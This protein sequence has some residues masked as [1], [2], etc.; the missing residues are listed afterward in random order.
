MAT[1]L[2][3][4]PVKDG[5][6]SREYPGALTLYHP[7]R[8]G[9]GGA[10]RLELRLR[11]RETGRYDCFFLEL[12]HQRPPRP[13]GQTAAFDW[14][15]KATVKL[16]FVDVCA[17]LAVLEGVQPAV[18]NQGNGLYHQTEDVSTLIAFRR[19]TER[20]GYFLGVSRKRNGGDH[21]F[22]GHFLVSVQE[23]IG[24]RCLLQSGLFFMTY[25]ASLRRAN[26]G[27]G[28]PVSEGAGM[29]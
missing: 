15:N 22:K 29:C 5:E 10:M 4:P 21:I 26:E 1:E 27:R 20:P 16:G 18:G 2:Q 14:E 24:L 13:G 19:T 7:N 6:R 11:G 9:T 25:L 8:K 12:A 28:G 3:T 17:L 23:G